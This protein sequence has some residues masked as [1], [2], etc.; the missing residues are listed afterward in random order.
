MK[1]ETKFEVEFCGISM[2][3]EGQGAII[4]GER[5]DQMA[6]FELWR[7]AEDAFTPFRDEKECKHQCGPFLFESVSTGD[8]PMDMKKRI[9]GRDVGL[10]MQMMMPISALRAMVALIEIQQCQDASSG[11]EV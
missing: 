3:F 8:G 6:L 5:F 1:S 2:K 7:K 10:G 11:M 4:D 9:N